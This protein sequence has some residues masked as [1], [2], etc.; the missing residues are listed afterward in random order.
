MLIEFDI[1]EIEAAGYDLTS[2]VVITNADNYVEVLETDR[3]KV[4]A[5]D[6]LMTI[7]S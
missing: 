6:Q 5:S 2:P 7:V 1:P 4:V 3:K